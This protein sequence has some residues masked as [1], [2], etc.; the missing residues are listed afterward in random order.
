MNLILKYVVFVII[1]ANVYSDDFMEEIFIKP[2]PPSHLY[3]HFQFVTLVS[4]ENSCKYIII[5]HPSSAGLIFL[6]A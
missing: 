2:L 5:L 3:A 4:S 1:V 6:Q